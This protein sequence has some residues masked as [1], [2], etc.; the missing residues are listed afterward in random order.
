MLDELLKVFREAIVP[1]AG[2]TRIRE[3]LVGD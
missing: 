2:K 1:L 3:W